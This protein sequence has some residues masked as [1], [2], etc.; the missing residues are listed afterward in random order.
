MN[1]FKAERDL[2][3]NALESGVLPQI[4]PCLRPLS[5]PFY[6]LIFSPSKKPSLHTLQSI[7]SRQWHRFKW[8]DYGDYGDF[9][10][11]FTICP[12]RRF[13]ACQILSSLCDA[14]VPFCAVYSCILSIVIR[15]SKDFQMR[16]TRQMQSTQQGRLSGALRSSKLNEDVALSSLTPQKGDFLEHGSGRGGHKNGDNFTKR[17][18]LLHEFTTYVHICSH[19]PRFAHRKIFFDEIPSDCRQFEWVPQ[20][21]KRVSDEIS[22]YT[23]W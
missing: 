18:S 8:G 2:S 4:R 12:F 23:P 11:N 14:F 9:D 7:P 5:S 21:Q 19:S 20:Q 10:P 17:Q 6:F 1:P 15:M 16:Q 13:S 22:W 3:F